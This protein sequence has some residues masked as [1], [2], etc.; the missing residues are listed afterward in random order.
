MKKYFYLLGA[1]LLVGCSGQSKTIESTTVTE[2][3]TEAPQT[4]P[5]PATAVIESSSEAVSIPDQDGLVDAIVNSLIDLGATD[6]SLDELIPDFSK[7][8]ISIDAVYTLSDGMKIV[9]HCFYD[10]MTK[11]WIVNYVDSYDNPDIIYYV[12]GYDDYYDIYD[13]RTDELIKESKRA[14]DESE[15]MSEAES[16]FESISDEGNAKLES[17]AE[18]YK[19]K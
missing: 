5:V 10:D 7:S 16:R 12:Y 1:L 3:Q 11:H 17:I 4:E 9:A 18:K 6:A 14:F 13:L 15:F 8:Y 2:L 19:T